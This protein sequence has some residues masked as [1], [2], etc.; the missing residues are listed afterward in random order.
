VAAVASTTPAAISGSMVDRIMPFPH[1]AQPG[2]PES[3][4]GIRRPSAPG[5]EPGVAS[6]AEIRGLRE[7]TL[8]STSISST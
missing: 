7:Q 2:S 3:G 1:Q 8:K 4:P 6:G 5:H